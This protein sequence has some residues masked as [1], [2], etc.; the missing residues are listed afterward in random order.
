MLHAHQLKPSFRAIALVLFLCSESL[1]SIAWGQEIFTPRRPIASLVKAHTIY[2]QTEVVKGGVQID[3][4]P[5]TDVITQRFQKVGYKIVTNFNAPHDVTVS[6][7]C[8]EPIRI[9]PPTNSTEKYVLQISSPP[10]LFHYAFHETPVDWQRIDII[11]YNEGIRATKSLN[12][13]AISSPSMTHP[14]PLSSQY[15][16]VLDF[17]ILLSAEWGQVPRLVVLL[18][19][20]QTSLQRRKKIIALLGEIQAEQA[21]PCLLDLLNNSTLQ[22]DAAWALGNFGA[23]AQEPLITLLQTH[24]DEKMQAAAAQSLGRI[25]AATGD[26][27]LTPLYIELLKK[28]GLDIQVKTEIVWAIGKSPDFRA[29]PTLESLEHEIWSIRSDEPQLKRLREAVDWSIREVRQGGHTGAY[30]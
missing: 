11:I 29:H 28:P 17:P 10:C 15:L 20:S 30:Y 13:L 16:R 7:Q 19:N 25:G 6:F 23:Q 8:E 3:P 9:Q 5:V 4:Q 21:L 26:T 2:L 14:A 18:E 24:P 1:I 22:I 12:Q 27:S